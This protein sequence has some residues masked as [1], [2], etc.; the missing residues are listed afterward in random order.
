MPPNPK[1]QFILDLQAWLTSL[2]NQGHDLIVS[3]DVNDTYNPDILSSSCH[4]AYTEGKPVMNT[5]HDGNL[6]TLISSCNLIDPLSLQ[7]PQHPYPASHLRD[8]SR[9]DFIFISCSLLLAVIRSGSLSLHSLFLQGDHGPYYLDLD[10]KILFAD[11]AFEIE[12]SKAQ[13]LQLSDPRIIDK[14]NEVLT[15]SLTYHKIFDK[16]NFLQTK[17]D[18]DKWDD[19]SHQTSIAV[20]QIITESTLHAEQSLGK[21][22]TSRFQWSPKLQLAVH[23]YHC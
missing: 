12:H 6:A 19:R 1:H 23:R 15:K 8:S 20:D 13:K 9:I 11:P 22:T 21:R 7:H 4:L 16:V 10:S 2:T 5:L 14:Y 17:L 3:L 18:T